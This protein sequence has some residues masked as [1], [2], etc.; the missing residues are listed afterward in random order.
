[1]SLCAI[2]TASG[3]GVDE[4]VAIES[5]E[6]A[7]GDIANDIAAGSLRAEADGGEGIDDLDE[8]IDGQPVQLDVLAGGDV[9]EVARVLLR[10]LADDAE[11]AAL[12]RMP[13]GRPMRI[14]KNSVALP[15]PPT[16]PVTPT[17]S[18]WV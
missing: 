1:M 11:S 6:R 8:A 15:S 7:A 10:E 2:S 5:G 17:P 12:V 4:L 3:T 18:P 16:P 14:M 9:G 13:L